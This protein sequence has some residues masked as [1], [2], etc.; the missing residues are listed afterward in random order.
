MEKL[1]DFIGKHTRTET[2]SFRD[3]DHICSSITERL[4]PSRLFIDKL[5]I[6]VHKEV[7]EWEECIGARKLFNDNSS[8][9][10]CKYQKTMVILI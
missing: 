7:I 4:E 9:I 2:V 1:A 5:R 6:L 8:F 3:K 10:T